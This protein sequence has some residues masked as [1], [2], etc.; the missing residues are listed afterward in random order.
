MNYLLFGV[1]LISI[2]VFREKYIIPGSKKNVDF[3]RTCVRGNENHRNYI[4]LIT[5]YTFSY[6]SKSNEATLDRSFLGY[7]VFTSSKNQSNI[8]ELE[9]ISREHRVM[10]GKR[11]LPGGSVPRAAFWSDKIC[12]SENG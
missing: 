9:T 7:R 10:Q 4:A 2:L 3:L 1:G 12:L 11:G 8:F 5:G 6:V